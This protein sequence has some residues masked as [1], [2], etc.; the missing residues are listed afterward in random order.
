VESL[1]ALFQNRNG[2]FCVVGPRQYLAVQPR[3]RHLHPAKGTPNNKHSD[4]REDATRWLPDRARSRF[5]YYSG[6]PKYGDLEQ[7]SSLFEFA[8]N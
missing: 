2:A 6:S 3:G 5:G 1:D 7:S 8:L 4:S